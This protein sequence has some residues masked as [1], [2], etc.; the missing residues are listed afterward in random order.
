M[1]NDSMLGIMAAVPSGIGVCC[2][3]GTGT[4]VSGVNA[5]G[6]TLQVGGFGFLSSDFGGGYYVALEVLR[7]VYSARYRDEAPT[8]L[9]QGVLGLL[10]ADADSDLL[11]LFHPEHL[12]LDKKLQYELDKLV[13]QC[14]EK[15]DD[16]SQAILH[17]VA[18]TLAKSTAGCIKELQFQ[19]CVTVALA[20]SLWIKGG[21]P[22]MMRLYCDEVEKRVPCK[23]EFVI[24]KQPPAVGAI[25]EAY[26]RL[27]K[28]VPSI[29][30]CERIFAAV[31]ES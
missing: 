5:E 31:E 23:C 1:C 20:G 4:S 24:L 21:Y 9:T 30:L 3:N 19:E 11:E 18:C 25:L 2:I 16:T 6:R 22:Q 27:T 7:Q 8:A 10:E 29:S 14:A 12:S 17:Q 26:R 13:F 15:G 28:E